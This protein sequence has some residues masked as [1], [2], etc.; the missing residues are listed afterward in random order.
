MGEFCG[1]G[2]AQLASLRFDLL[3]H[4]QKLK[5]AHCVATAKSFEK[6]IAL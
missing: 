6:S 1:L 3:C 2:S 5:L 4:E